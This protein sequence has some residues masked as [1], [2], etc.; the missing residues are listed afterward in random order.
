MVCGDS[1]EYVVGL[2]WSWVAVRCSTK[3][4]DGGGSNCETHVKV[5]ICKSLLGVTPPDIKCETYAKVFSFFSEKTVG[6]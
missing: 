5:P 4:R 2:D 6:S 3:P 1:D